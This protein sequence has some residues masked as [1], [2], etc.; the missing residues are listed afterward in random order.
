MNTKIYHEITNEE[1]LEVIESVG[2]KT[3]NNDQV[4]KALKYIIKI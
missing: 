3:Y 2:F 4:T 1:F